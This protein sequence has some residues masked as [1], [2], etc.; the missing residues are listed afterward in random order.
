MN[1]PNAYSLNVSGR[2]LDLSSPKVMGIVNYTPDS[3]YQGVSD[4]VWDAD[5]LDIGAYS[6]RP[7][8]EE[9][10]EEEE[11]RRLEAFFAAHPHLVGG[12]VPLSID[13]FRASV[14]R[15]CIEEYGVG[16]VNDVSGGR[17][18]EMFRTV[19]E[20]RVPYV[21]THSEEF[22]GVAAML[23]D[24]IIKVQTLRDLGMN[25][26]IIDPGFG[27]GKTLEDNYDVM[28]NLEQMKALALPILVGVSRKSMI[29]KALGCSA[30]QALNGTTILNTLALRKG[31]NILRVHDVSEAREIITILD[32]LE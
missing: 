9:V 8:H 7:G 32:K 20:L 2:L 24:L 10:S 1:N 29:Q 23:K 27:F 17:D 4:D 14:A 16:M 22:H 31:A 15:R 25:D 12:T 5:I 19:A 26:I 28:R 11:M 6:T 13:T 18:A 21:L 30:E 3:F